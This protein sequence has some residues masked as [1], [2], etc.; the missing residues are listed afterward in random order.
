MNNLFS[1]FFSSTLMF[2]FHISWWEIHKLDTKRFNLSFNCSLNMDLNSITDWSCWIKWWLT[3]I[4][5]Y[6][7]EKTK[8]N[9]VNSF[10]NWFKKTVVYLNEEEWYSFYLESSSFFKNKGWFSFFISSL[11]MREWRSLCSQK[12]QKFMVSGKKNG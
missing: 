7:I 6:L 9:T 5:A 12:L 8:K 4:E 10:Y 2:K 1:Y 3:K 11:R